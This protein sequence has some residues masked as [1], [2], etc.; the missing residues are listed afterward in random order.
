[1]TFR[2]RSRYFAVSMFSALL[3]ASSAVL[4]REVPERPSPAAACRAWS[5]HFGD[6]IEQHRMAHE[7][8]DAT[9]ASVT[10][11]FGTAR[12]AC[13]YGDFKNGL[14]LYETIPLGPVRAH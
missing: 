9:I 1:M 7:L 4:A 6:L 8:D 2:L 12:A 14:R 10:E 3:L 11:Q 13:Y 5:E